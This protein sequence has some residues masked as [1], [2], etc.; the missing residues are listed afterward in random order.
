MV[1]RSD[2]NSGFVIYASWNGATD[3]DHWTVFAGSE[4][5]GLQPVG[6]QRWSGFETTIVV[7]SDGPVFQVAAIDRHGNELGRSE[8]T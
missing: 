8:T 3:I 6:S 7:N 5:A 2:G 1:A 4:P